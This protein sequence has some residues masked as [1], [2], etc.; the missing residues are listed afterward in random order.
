V[1]EHRPP[2]DHRIRLLQ[3]SLQQPWCP[4]AHDKSPVRST[5]R[6][7]FA[8][9]TDV[10]AVKSREKRRLP[11]A[12]MMHGVCRDARRHHGAGGR[13]RTSSSPPRGREPTRPPALGLSMKRLTQ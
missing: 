6:D 13:N 9:C 11:R 3:H 2:I 5:R 1:T 8:R 4:E 12:M 7:A 10:V